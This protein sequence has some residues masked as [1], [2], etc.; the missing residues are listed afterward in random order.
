[1]AHFRMKPGSKQKAVKAM[2]AAAEKRKKRIA[3]ALG[4][5][6]GDT[7]GEIQTELLAVGAH[8]QG[9]LQAATTHDPVQEKGTKLTVRMHNDLEHASVVEFGRKPKSGLPPPLLPLVGWAGRKGIIRNLPRNISFG[10][11]WAKKWAASGAIMRRILKSKG[12]KKGKQKPLDP[13][14]KDLLTVRMIANKI[15]E[16]GIVGRFPFTRVRDRRAKT[17]NR[18]IA[19]LVNSAR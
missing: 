18:E 9:T 1:M 5:W 11:E 6:A 15:F 7:V 13:D 4:I 3:L 14:V 12:T 17:M 2:T 8:D 16:K 10:G 19:A